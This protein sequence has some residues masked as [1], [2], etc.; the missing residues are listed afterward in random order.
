[1]TNEQIVSEIKKHDSREV[2]LYQRL[3]EQNRAL[4]KKF[5]KPYLEHCEL[6]DLMQECYFGLVEAV[7]HYESD[8]EVLFMSFASYWIDRQLRRY[9]QNC[10]EIYRLP[11]HYNSLIP[12]YKKFIYEYQ[13]EHDHKPTDDEILKALHIRHDTLEIIQQFLKGCISSNTPL[14]TEDGV[15]TIE[16]TLQADISVENDTVEDLYK[17]YESNELWAICEAFTKDK[18]FEVLRCYY[19]NGMTYKQIGESLNLS[20]QR[21]EQLKRRAITNL[22][23]GRAKRR[24]IERLEVVD[25]GLYKGS[26]N[27]YKLREHTS[28]TEHIALK[29]IEIKEGLTKVS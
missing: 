17:D 25:S 19:I 16:D 12:R 26:F 13:Q 8:K 3:Y 4:L 24:L 9:I 10:C 27:Q 1:M 6:D 11:Q 29:D 20:K 5:C 28:I 14:D 22:R 18:E 2:D 7:E 23:T 21:I 15:F